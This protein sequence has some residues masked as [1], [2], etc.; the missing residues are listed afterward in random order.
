MDHHDGHRTCATGE[1]EGETSLP[2][3]SEKYGGDLDDV[4]GLAR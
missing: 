3:S 4:E 1:K 2:A